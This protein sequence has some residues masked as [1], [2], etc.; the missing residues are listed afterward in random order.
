MKEI[1]LASAQLVDA[2]QF[3]ARLAIDIEQATRRIYLQTM[4]LDDKGAMRQVFDAL[5]HAVQ[6]GVAVSVAFDKRVNIVKRP[7]AYRRLQRYFR[8]TGIEP[9]YLGDIKTGHSPVSGRSHG[10][11]YVCDDIVYFGGGINL[12]GHSFECYDYMFRL[13]SAGLA[14]VYDKI[15]AESLP[16]ADKRDHSH[17]L[18]AKSTLL[19]DG[20][21]KKHSLI[22]D[23]ALELA[24]DAQK[25][26]YLSQLSPAG[27]LARRYRPLDVVYK[28]NRTRSAKSTHSKVVIPVDSTTSRTRNCYKGSCYIHGK[29]IVVER[30][31]GSLVALTGSHNFATPG[32]R[33]GTKEIALLTTNQE[34]CQRLLKYVQTTV[35]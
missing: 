20:G 4:E 11:G 19:V 1:S 9:V 29:C 10:K 13:E 6:R 16:G 22:L 23:T 18:S 31:N 30:S 28:Y 35:V 25:V 17:W 21:S 2:R 8:D 7:R 32:I 15:F 14:A 27:R 12:T 3:A 34:L 5:A 26:W 24:A 33:V